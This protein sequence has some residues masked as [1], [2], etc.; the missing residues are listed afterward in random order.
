MGWQHVSVTVEFDKRT[1]RWEVMCFVRDLFWDDG[2]WVIQFH[3]PK[4]E[5]VNFHPCCLHLWGYIGDGEFKQPT[6]DSIL[7]GPMSRKP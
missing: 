5:Y 7:V 2:D 6:P 1:P 4:K 3:P